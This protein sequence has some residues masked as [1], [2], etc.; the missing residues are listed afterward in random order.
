MVTPKPIKSLPAR[1][2]GL[3]MNG[4][5]V[6]KG[7]VWSIQLSTYK[8]MLIKIQAVTWVWL[9][10]YHLNLTHS[11]FL[12]KVKGLRSKIAHTCGNETHTS[13][14]RS[15]QKR[16]AHKKSDI[17]KN[18]SLNMQVTFEAANQL[19]KSI[20]L[21]RSLRVKLESNVTWLKKMWH[22]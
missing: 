13:G 9:C 22:P 17:P 20:L 12:I 6:W 18:W 7:N 15:P 4:I 21:T 19:S 8:V 11:L 3:S 14:K 5:W 10:L 16:E 2:L 1:G